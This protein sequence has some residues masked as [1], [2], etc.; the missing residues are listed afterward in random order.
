MNHFTCTPAD[1]AA[2]AMHEA[3]HAVAAVLLGGTITEVT[4]DPDGG[5]LTGFTG[6]STGAVPEVAYAGPYAEARHRAGR[7]PTLGQI[8]DDLRNCD[9]DRAALIA[10]GSPWPRGIEGA[11]EFLL[12][13]IARV[14][15]ALNTSGR[16]DHD[17]VAAALGFPAGDRPVVV[18]SLCGSVGTL[19]CHLPRRVSPLPPVRMR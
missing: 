18:A 1:R 12:P 8:Q 14:A 13:H 6:V 19:E 7:L 9:L 17:Q 3:G 10:S 2:A 11:V 16:L 5:G 4:L 15:L